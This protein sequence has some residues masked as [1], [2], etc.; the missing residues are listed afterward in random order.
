MKVVGQETVSV[1]KQSASAWA[2]ASL[3]NLGPGFDILGIAID[4][5]GD[6]IEAVLTDRPGIS[7]SYAA[8]SAWTGTTDPAQNTAGVAASKTLEVLDYGGG[9]EIII[10]KNIAPGSGVG[11]SA[12]SAVAAAWAVNAIFGLPLTKKDLV[13]AVLDG[14]TI[15]SGSKHGDN[16]IP[17]LFGGSVIVSASD[18]SQYRHIHVKDDL[19]IT[20]IL[21]AVQ[22]LTR[23]AR[24]MLPET[25]TFSRAIRHASSLAM[26]VDALKDGDWRAFGRFIMEDEI[27]EPVRGK[28]L[29]CFDSI[30][31]A[32]LTAGAYGCALSGS[33]PAMFAVSENENVAESIRK[34]MFEACDAAGIE[35]TSIVTTP[36]NKG[37]RE[38][39]QPEI[40]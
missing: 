22:I 18:P 40:A 32:A 25:V 11:S 8:N 26:L 38:W 20:I 12:S 16:V 28:L 15:A 13:D 23:A 31:E 21:P 7:I 39:D 17:S 6:K 37:V 29:S 34:A 2:P 14:E 5:W 27:I 36:D 33:G 30:R 19:Y 9:V 35:S 1:M 3:S 4:A 10:S 24:A